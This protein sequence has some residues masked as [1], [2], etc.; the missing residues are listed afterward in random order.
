[1][2]VLLTAEVLML[3]EK[4][5]LSFERIEGGKIRVRVTGWGDFKVIYPDQMLRFA[6][7][8]IRCVLP[9]KTGFPTKGPCDQ[10][11]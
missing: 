8:G 6:T 1:M 10:A 11:V 2:A 7:S 3:S 9:A 5:T 4:A